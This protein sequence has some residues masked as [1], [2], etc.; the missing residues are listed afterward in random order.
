MIKKMSVSGVFKGIRL[1]FPCSNC[2]EG[3][4]QVGHVGKHAL[5]RNA[6]SKPTDPVEE[7]DATLPH[8]RGRQL[9]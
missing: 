9:L 8:F 3:A 7:V 4:E 6:R 5:I 2:N 1:S